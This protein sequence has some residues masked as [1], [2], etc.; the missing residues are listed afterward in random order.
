MSQDMINKIK[1][2]MSIQ[3]LE[4]LLMPLNDSMRTIDIAAAITHMAQQQ[5]FWASRQHGSRRSTGQDHDSAAMQQQLLDA[6]AAQL[7]RRCTNAV[8]ARP[9]ACC[10]HGRSWSMAMQMHWQPAWAASLM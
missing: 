10:G 8:R 4:H 1:A 5:G 9:P 6:L 7:Q 2:T 3:E